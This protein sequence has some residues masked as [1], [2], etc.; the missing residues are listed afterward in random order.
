MRTNQAHL[1]VC[2]SPTLL[3]FVDEIASSAA[4]GPIL[5]APC[6]YGRNSVALANRGCTVIGVDNDL[7]RIRILETTKGQYISDAA[8]GRDRAGQIKLICADLS[9]VDR[10]PLK[11]SSLSAIVC[12]HFPVV[13]L[14]D[15]FVAALRTGG[16]L[17]IETFGGHGG[18]YLD[19]PKKGQLRSMIQPRADLRFY[20][21]RMAGP[22][23][24]NGVSVKLFA[25][26]TR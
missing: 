21:E 11:A 2:P 18:N 24:A 22:A 9:G 23:Y 12:V 13:E 5:D 15:Q 1:P 25:Q 20:Q 4:T 10:L 19:L 26:K 17:Y 16:Y 6:G 7:S 14:V 8:P 3:K